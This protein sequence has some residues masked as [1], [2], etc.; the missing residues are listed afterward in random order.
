M[1]LFPLSVVGSCLVA[2]ATPLLGPV[3]AQAQCPFDWLPGQGVPGVL[4]KVSA[5]TVWDPD[6]PGPQPELLVMGGSFRIAGDV[7]ASR[8]AAWNGSNFQSLGSGVDGDD[9]AAFVY[10]LSLFHGELLAGG[11]FSTAG[12]VSA[13]SCWN[14]PPGSTTSRAAAASSSATCWPPRPG[15]DLEAGQ[16][17]VTIGRQRPALAQL[18]HDHGAR[19]VG[20]RECREPARSRE[21]RTCSRFPME[22]RG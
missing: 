8:V 16:L 10:A 13:N 18:A 12:G 22:C 21:T 17:E 5:A 19:A 7:V 3:A 15:H 14:A 2:S 20:E 4:G 6:G 9:G 11:Y 1:R